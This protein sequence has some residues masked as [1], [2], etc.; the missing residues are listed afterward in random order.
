MAVAR[1]ALTSFADGEGRRRP[2]RA[3][4]VREHGR[5]ASCEIPI[6]AGHPDV[7][8]RRSG[9]G[10]VLMPG[11]ARPGDRGLRPD[12]RAGRHVRGRDSSRGHLEETHDEETGKGQAELR[13]QSSNGSTCPCLG[14]Y[15]TGRKPV[16]RTFVLDRKMERRSSGGGIAEALP[17]GPLIEELQ[18]LF[19]LDRATVQAKLQ[20]VLAGLPHHRTGRQPQ[21]LHDLRLD[22][23]RDGR[24]AGAGAREETAG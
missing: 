8:R 13:H 11:R 5:E 1:L 21:M 17:R 6:V 23:G 16:N 9:D 12:R 14:G 20:E 24:S 22:R 2:P 15:R 3:V 4:R 7:G 10:L 18:R 19:A